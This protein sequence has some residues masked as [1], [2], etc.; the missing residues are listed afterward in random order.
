M[1]PKKVVYMQHNK[2]KVVNSGTNTEYSS[3]PNFYYKRPNFQ[4]PETKAI[5]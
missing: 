1:L 3:N 5:H 2:K 4:R